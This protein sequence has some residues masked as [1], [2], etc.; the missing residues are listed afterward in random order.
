MCVMS[1][2]V[3]VTFVNIHY[4]FLPFGYPSPLKEVLALCFPAVRRRR[5]RGTGGCVVSEGTRGGMSQGGSGGGVPSTVREEGSKLWL[6]V[7]NASA[8]HALL[9][10]PL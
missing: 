2:E 6:G 7:G 5:G 1:W 4:Y 8:T 10:S 9:P 3:H